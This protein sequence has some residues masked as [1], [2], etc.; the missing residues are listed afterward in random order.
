M[1]SYLI[2]PSAAQLKTSDHFDG[3]PAL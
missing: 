1:N 2:S 3:W